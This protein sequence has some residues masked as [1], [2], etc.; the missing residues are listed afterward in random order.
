M[1][2]GSA[3]ISQ[4]PK[5][6][7]PASDDGAR[8]STEQSA[9]Q[10]PEQHQLILP[11]VLRWKVDNGPA[12]DEDHDG[13][14]AVLVVQFE[15]ELSFDGNVIVPTPGLPPAC[16]GTQCWLIVRLPD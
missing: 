11:G 12:T 9:T 10:E 15:D 16:R 5:G 13:A 2:S 4:I 1:T 6:P 7:A 14:T 8:A 3:T